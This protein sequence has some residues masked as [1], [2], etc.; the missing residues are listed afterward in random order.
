MEVWL[1]CHILG[2][3]LTS[4]VTLSL[5]ICSI[6]ARVKIRA[7]VFSSL[8]SLVAPLKRVPS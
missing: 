6:R 8:V 7:Q 1:D 5:I 4:Q 3:R 2:I